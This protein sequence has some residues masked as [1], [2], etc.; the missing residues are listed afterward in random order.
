MLF[1]LYY[2]KARQRRC[3]SVGQSTRFI[4]VVSLVQIQ[5]PLPYGTLEKRLN[6]PASHAGI[7]GFESHTCHHHFPSQKSSVCIAEDFLYLIFI[8]FSASIS[9]PAGAGRPRIWDDHND[10]QKNSQS[11]AIAENH[12]FHKTTMS[13]DYPQFPPA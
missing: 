1:F 4:P 10:Q 12:I 5:S 13:A 9:Y 8:F 3:S 11:Y 2:N 6:S 7:H